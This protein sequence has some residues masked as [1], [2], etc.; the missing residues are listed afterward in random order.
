MQR[1]TSVFPTAQHSLL[2]ID[3]RAHLSGIGASSGHR[4][5]Q[6][7]GTEQ[8]LMIDLVRGGV[9][10]I[11]HPQRPDRPCKTNKQSAS[12]AHS[13]ARP[14]DVHCCHHI[15]HDGS[16]LH[17]CVVERRVHVGQVRVT[18]A[19]GVANMGG[20]RLTEHPRLTSLGIYIV[21]IVYE[22][23][24]ELQMHPVL[25]TSLIMQEHTCTCTH[26]PMCACPLKKGWKAPAW[27]QRVNSS[28]EGSPK[29]P[30]KDQ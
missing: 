10:R 16:T 13:L 6:D 24:I 15:P 22:F 21:H 8:K 25:L 26:S 20:V 7:V 3:A 23:S 5:H 29:K 1:S 11:L 9:L 27:N 14:L 4:A 18:S 17:G 19:N 28:A 30:P 2:Y 12:R